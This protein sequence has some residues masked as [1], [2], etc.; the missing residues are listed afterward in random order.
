MMNKVKIDLISGFLGAGKTTF[1]KRLMEGVFLDEKIVI[2]ENE[3]GKVN[4][5]LETLGMAGLHV[6][7]IQAGCICCSSSQELQ[8]GIL[9]ILNEFEPDRIIVEPTGI[10]KLSEIIEIFKN[11]YL[12]EQCS[13]EHIITIVDSKNYYLRTMI[14]KDFF[15]DQIRASEVIFL[16]KTDNMNEEQIFRIIAEIYKIKPSCRII[17]DPWGSIS[18]DQFK[19][20]MNPWEDKKEQNNSRLSLRIKYINDFESYEYTKDE[21]VNI[22]KIKLF[23]KCVENSIYGEVHRIKG[24]CMDSQFGPYSVDYVP[25]ETVIKLL[26]DQQRK[27]E[28]SLICIIGRNMESK[29]L[30]RFFKP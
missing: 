11:G 18:I 30:K 16:S 21:Y 10:A 29:K 17:S 23:I 25:G 14:S 2:L 15:E 8:T 20:L 22:D 1:I 24:I 26:P 19:K 6:K 4:I 7:P 12:S 13:L 27:E 5:D 28:I 3:F 9:E